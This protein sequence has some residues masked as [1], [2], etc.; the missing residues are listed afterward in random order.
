MNDADDTRNRPPPSWSV[1]PKPAER[2][3]NGRFRKGSS[4]NARGRPPK[5]ERALTKRAYYRDVLKEMD[6]TIEIGGEEVTPVQLLVRTRL[7]LAAK[8]DRRAIAD[9]LEMFKGAI[10]FVE[11]AN[12]SDSQILELSEDRASRNPNRLD[13]EF[14]K[15]L[16]EQRRKAKKI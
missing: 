6:R 2:E 5:E 16:N 9:V 3:S 14:A 12:P 10:E 13:P 4:G 8:G 15:L 1:P 7:S 11:A